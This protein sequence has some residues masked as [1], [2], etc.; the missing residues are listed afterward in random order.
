MH[1]PSAIWSSRLIV[2]DRNISNI[3]NVILSQGSSALLATV[4]K[5]NQLHKLAPPDAENRLFIDYRI[6]PIL[7]DLCY[8]AGLASTAYE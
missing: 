4:G 2:I 5:I 3:Q 8:H 6:P 1:Q 7:H